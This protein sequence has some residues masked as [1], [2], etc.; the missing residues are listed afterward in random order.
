MRPEFD[1]GDAVRVTRN[2]R[3][4]GTY[5]GMAVGDL[6]VRRGSTGTV[7]GV[8]TF[9]QDQII[10][11]VHFLEIDR[12][13]GCR[14]EEVIAA[15]APWA[16]SRFESRDKVLAGKAFSVRG[17]VVVDKGAIGEIIR[18][19][20]DMPAGVHYHINFPGYML[21]I[22]ETSVDPL[23]QPVP[24]RRIHADTAEEEPAQ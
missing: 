5:P 12:I 16:P 11:T 14:A 18:V 19:V 2:V 17:E 24:R 4:D 9:L 21:C 10:Y 7:I 23:P 22:P 13:I 20:R 6:L 15:D 1:Y 3:D 8:G